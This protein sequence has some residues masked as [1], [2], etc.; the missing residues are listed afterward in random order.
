[1]TVIAFLIVA[2]VV[3]VAL[4]DWALSMICAGGFILCLRLL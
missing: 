3:C 2:L 4:E 1:M